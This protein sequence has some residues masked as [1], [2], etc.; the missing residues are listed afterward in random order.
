[1]E[2]LLRFR[3][4]FTTPSQA[5][6]CLPTIVYC[7]FLNLLCSNCRPLH[8]RWYNNNHCL[9]IS[10]Y[11]VSLILPFQ[12]QSTTLISVFQLSTMC[13]PLT[14]VAIS[15]PCK[16]QLSSIMTILVYPTSNTFKIC[17]PYLYQHFNIL[18]HI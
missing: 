8:H 18:T 13:L 2:L 10:I 3:N 1:M 16:L 9:P 5:Y 7:T 12:C 15:L 14:N 11:V 17:A 4:L 6:N